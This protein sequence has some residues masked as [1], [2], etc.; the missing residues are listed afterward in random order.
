MLRPAFGGQ[1]Q[2]C[3]LVRTLGRRLGPCSIPPPCCLAITGNHKVAF[4]RAI[5]GLWRRPRSV[6]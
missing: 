6:A 3:S 4:A 5:A 1:G 2:L